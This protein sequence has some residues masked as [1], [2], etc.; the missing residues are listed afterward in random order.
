[1]GKTL[2][3]KRLVEKLQSNLD[4]GSVD[5]YEEEESY[6]EESE[7]VLH[8]TVPLYEKSVNCCQVAST[9]LKSFA[10][11]DSSCPKIIH[12]DI[13]YEVVVIVDEINEF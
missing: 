1:M 10:P 8:V 11:S 2:Y 12:L 4:S 7:D 13:A 6:E 9:L 5:E 3:K